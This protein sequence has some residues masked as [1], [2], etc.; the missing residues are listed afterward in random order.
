MW[1]VDI[2]ANRA[3]QVLHPGVVG[4]DSIDKIL[5]LTTNYHLEIKGNEKARLTFFAKHVNMR[6]NMRVSFFADLSGDCDFVVGFEAQR[7]L[8]FVEIVKGNGDSGLG[9]ATLPVFINQVLEVG[10]SYLA[11]KQRNAWTRL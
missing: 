5:V 2:E 3:E 4:I 6:V 7:T 10:G 11:V 1:V 8:T 9:D